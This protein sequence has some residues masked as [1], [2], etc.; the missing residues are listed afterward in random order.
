[1]ISPEEGYLD[2]HQ[3]LLGCHPILVIAR[4]LFQERFGRKGL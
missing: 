3:L 1:M 4:T 2:P